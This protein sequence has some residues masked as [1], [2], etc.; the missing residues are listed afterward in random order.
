MQKLRDSQKILDCKFVT[1]IL[2]EPK[3][4]DL[5]I[6]Q[7]GHLDGSLKFLFEVLNRKFDLLAYH[8]FLDVLGYVHLH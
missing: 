1:Q 3:E 2:K 4:V 6:G 7:H 8:V 5:E